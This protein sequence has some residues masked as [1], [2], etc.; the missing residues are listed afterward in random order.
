MID[1][2]L[3]L[4]F[5][6]NIFFL[7]TFIFNVLLFLWPDSCQGSIP[8]NFFFLCV[9]GKESLFVIWMLQL[10]GCESLLLS[11][12]LIIGAL[13]VALHWSTTPWLQLLY[14]GFHFSVFILHCIESCCSV[15]VIHK[16]MEFG[17]KLITIYKSQNICKPR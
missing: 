4:I 6:W 1:R 16:E 15:L 12:F 11:L 5:I 7:K 9:S 2:G 10:D 13:W 8:N 14:F 17:L 3:I